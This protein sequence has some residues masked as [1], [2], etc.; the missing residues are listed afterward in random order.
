LNVNPMTTITSCHKQKQKN[1]QKQKI[2]IHISKT[3]KM[4]L[5][6]FFDFLQKIF[7]FLRFE[8]YH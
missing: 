1:K 5:V 8:R 7:L 2:S 6:R 3:R 4:F